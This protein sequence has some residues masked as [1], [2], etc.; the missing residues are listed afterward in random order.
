MR[1]LV[2]DVPVPQWQSALSL[3]GTLVVATV[4]GIWLLRNKEI[5]R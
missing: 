3:L 5:F 4:L 2:Q 1:A